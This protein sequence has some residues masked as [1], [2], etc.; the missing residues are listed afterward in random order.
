MSTNIKIIGSFIET[1]LEMHLYKMSGI[2][3][4][5]L[6]HKPD[7]RVVLRVNS[8]LLMI[9]TSKC[10]AR[11]RQ[12][13]YLS[14]SRPPSQKNQRANKVQSTNIIDIIFKFSYLYIGQ[15]VCQCILPQGIIVHFPSANLAWSDIWYII[16]FI[17]NTV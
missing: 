12:T 17:S 15:R 7:H 13:Y 16:V 2:V 14:L 5:I 11:E 10:F 3:L 1:S 8:S 4:S 6:F 9:N